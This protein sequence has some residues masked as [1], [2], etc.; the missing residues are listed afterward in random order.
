[1]KNH[2]GVPST[3]IFS[4]GNPSRGDDAIGPCMTET[5]SNKCN[6][7]I[8]LLSDFQLQI[9]H[10]LDLD[11]RDRVLFIDASISASTPF[12]FYRLHAQRD[13]SYT[14]HAMSP[15]S[16]LAVY[17]QVRQQAAPAAFMLS[18][19][20]Q[21][22]KLGAEISTLAR[23]HLEVAIDFIDNQLLTEDLQVWNQLAEHQGQKI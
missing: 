21:S 8:D 13:H 23:H 5:L 4:W 7:S 10:V 11:H 18:V 17:E 15:Q 3:L 2:D 22:F 6:S 1:M 9:E 14:S 12:E 20:A 16:L 19:A